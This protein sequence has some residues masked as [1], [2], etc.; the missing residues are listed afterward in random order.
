[1]L[2]VNFCGI[3]FTGKRISGFLFVS[4]AQILVL[5][6]FNQTNEIVFKHRF[7]PHTCHRRPRTWHPQTAVCSQYFIF[8]LYCYLCSRLAVTLNC[9]SIKC[10]YARS[11]GNSVPATSYAMKKKTVIK[12]TRLRFYDLVPY[13]VEWVNIVHHNEYYSPKAENVTRLIKII[14]AAIVYLPLF[15]LASR[16]VSSDSAMI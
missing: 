12:S 5:L 9:R 15:V 1:M 14:T 16:A 6:Q 10:S 11:G 2:S 3:I 13:L 7:Q 8:Y 4:L